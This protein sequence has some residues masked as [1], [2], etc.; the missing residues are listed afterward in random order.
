MTVNGN[1]LP[2]EVLVI[3]NPDGSSSIVPNPYTGLDLSPDAVVTPEGSLVLTS[4]TDIRHQTDGT[5]TINGKKL[6]PGT[7][8]EKQADG[9]VLIKNNNKSFNAPESPGTAAAILGGAQLPPSA[10]VTEAGVVLPKTSQVKQNPDGSFVIDGQTL[11]PGCQV[12]Q[13]VDGSYVVLTSEPPFLS[14]N[15]ATL[16]QGSVVT[17]PGSLT[18]PKDTVITRTWDGLIVANGAV[19]PPGT[20][21]EVNTDGSVTVNT[22]GQIAEATPLCQTSSAGIVSV[23][24]TQL[25]SGT[26]LGKDG[27][28]SLPRSAKLTTT[29]DGSVCIDGKVLPPGTQT[30]TNPDGSISLLLPPDSSPPSNQQLSV[31]KNPDGSLSLGSIKLSRGATQNVDGSISLPASTKVSRAPDGSQLVDG[32]KLP[33]GAAL[34]KNSDGS[35]SI[36]S[37]QSNPNMKASSDGTLTLGNIALPPGSSANMD[38]SIRLARGSKIE[39]NKDGSVSVNGKPLPAGYDCRPNGD[40]TFNI[41]PLPSSVERGKDGCLSVGKIKLP[42]GSSPAPDGSILIPPTADLVTSQD[43]GVSLN[44]KT[45]P[46]GTKLRVNADGSKSLVLPRS[47]RPGS[48]TGFVFACLTYIHLVQ[49][50]FSN[51]NCKYIRVTKCKYHQQFSCKHSTQPSLWQRDRVK[52]QGTIQSCG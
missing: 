36:V 20:T 11:P 10:Q 52:G 7:H 30:K 3:T 17:K 49:E 38:G 46:P 44:G 47:S 28:V 42:R 23:A 31:K 26:R 16:P 9:S 22:G 14:V 24:G 13:N 45:F 35:F 18:L 41:T 19:M 8:V 34:V 15:G 21:V 37:S 25:P 29:Q 2:A 40:G 27:T 4:L 51:V 6:P 1:I 32:K 39:Q 50:C 48:E 33:P 5:V 43:G 12:E